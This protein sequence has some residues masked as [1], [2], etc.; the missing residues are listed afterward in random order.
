MT[1][2]L[3][4][5]KFKIEYDKENITSS[6]PSLTNYEIE[7]FLDK[8]YYALIA[9]KITGNNPRGAIYDYDVKSI[10]DLNGLLNSSDI[11]LTKHGNENVYEGNIPTEFLYY[12]NSK[13][14][15]PFVCPIQIVTKSTANRFLQTPYNKPWIK[16][17][18]CYIQENKFFLVADP[19]NDRQLTVNMAFV[20]K[21]KSFVNLASDSEFELNDSMAEE[22]ISLAIIFALENIESPRLSSKLNTKGLEG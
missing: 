8:A 4:L 17:P 5:T 11:Q 15:D 19:D 13:V 3:I 10:S 1:K 16:I 20:K 14:I 2:E 7:T 22:L 18:V 6:Y 12:I 9:Q 21:P